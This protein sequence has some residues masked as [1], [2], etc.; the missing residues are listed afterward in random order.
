M[1]AFAPGAVFLT[2]PSEDGITTLK[3]Y[4][5]VPADVPQITAN[6][7]ADVLG[8]IDSLATGEHKHRTLVMDALGGFER[9]CHEEVCARDFRGE[10]GD[11]GFASYHKGYQVAL[12]D[13]RM[14][15]NG[16]DRLRDRGMS[17]II[18]GH[19]NVKNY[20]N[21]EGEDYDRY[22]P[23][24]HASTWALTHKWADLVIFQQYV[25]VIDDKGKA[26]GGQDRV[27][28]TEYHPAYDAKNRM[29]LPGDIDMG[30]SGKEAWNNLANALK[31]CMGKD[32]NQNG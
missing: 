25:T 21:P 5:R 12:T 19:S 7:W 4:G 17:V 3:N 28:L 1:A 23:D 29:G 18:L 13:W 14:F 8:T 9:L 6:N 10:W 15:L 11:K 24:V 16:L 27:M 30:T 2:D 31:A 32:V 20:K 22:I 26:K